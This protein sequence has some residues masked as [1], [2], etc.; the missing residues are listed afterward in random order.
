MKNDCSGI[1]CVY[2]AQEDVSSTDRSGDGSKKGS[3]R[4]KDNDAQSGRINNPT[5]ISQGKLEVTNVSIE[6]HGRAEDGADGSQSKKGVAAGAGSVKSATLVNQ[7]KRKAEVC[8]G[9]GSEG[10]IDDRSSSKKR[11]EAVPRVHVHKMWKRSG[12]KEKRNRRMDD[13]RKSARAMTAS[14]DQITLED[15]DDVNSMGQSPNAGTAPANIDQISLA[16]DDH[17]VNSTGQTT[18]TD[19]ITNCVRAMTESFHQMSM[20]DDGDFPCKEISTKAMPESPRFTIKEPLF[21]CCENCHRWSYEDPEMVVLE[22]REVTDSNIKTTR[23]NDDDASVGSDDAVVNVCHNFTVREDDACGGS[24]DV[25]MCSCL[26]DIMT[27]VK[28]PKFRWRAQLCYID[29]PETVTSGEPWLES[30]DLCRHC[31]MYITG[32]FDCNDEFDPIAM[33]K[34]WLRENILCPQ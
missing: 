17:H 6:I 1:Y 21:K 34:T 3:N 24:L 33:K 16:D 2:C 5:V 10:V 32:R 11:K 29:Q 9:S 23:S 31:R 28:R 4:K 20:D 19:N 26:L 8:V 25:M 22:S 7:R 27:I 13:I 14:F 30:M 15:D 18:T 12:R